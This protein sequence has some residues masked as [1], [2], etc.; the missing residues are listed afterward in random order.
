MN[1]LPV[2]LLTTDGSFKASV[3]TGGYAGV[4][5]M[6]DQFLATIGNDNETTINR[7][8]LMAVLSSLRQLTM[9]CR[10][11]IVSDSQYVV[12]GITQWLTGWIANAWI[13][14][15][16]QPVGNRDLWEEM[17]QH[18]QTHVITAEWVKGHK[19]HVNIELCDQLA[20]WAA[21]STEDYSF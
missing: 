19:G 10:V 15:A 16:R 1:N 18:M 7:M 2:V 4:L 6:G 20:G 13:T 12:K 5:Q 14:S 21:F 17:W 11:H 8:E 3:Q 9:P